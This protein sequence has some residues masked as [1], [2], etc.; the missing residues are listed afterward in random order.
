MRLSCPGV[1]C[2]STNNDAENILVYPHIYTELSNSFLGMKST[3]VF[4]YVG[5]T[6]S[7]ITNYY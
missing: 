5:R 3:A 6:I 1:V 7:F 2:T 4:F